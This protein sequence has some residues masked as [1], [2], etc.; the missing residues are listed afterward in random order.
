MRDGMV[1]PESHPAFGRIYVDLPGNL[2]VLRTSP[3]RVPADPEPWDVFDPEGVWLGA[4][5]LPA[6][7]TMREIGDDYVAGVWRDEL[8][9]EYVRVYRLLKS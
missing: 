6:R 2:W 4:V 8:D 9:V 7:F 5:A 3:D 1:Y